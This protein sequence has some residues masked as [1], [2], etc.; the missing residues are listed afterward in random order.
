MAGLLLRGNIAIGMFQKE[1]TDFL[2][3]HN[4]NSNVSK[5]E[6][7]IFEPPHVTKKHRFCVTDEDTIRDINT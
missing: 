7:R 3:R 1:K 5:G 2:S 4:S 6:D